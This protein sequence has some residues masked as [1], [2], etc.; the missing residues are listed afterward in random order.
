MPAIEV[1]PVSASAGEPVKKVYLIN[2]SLSLNAGIAAIAQDYKV[3]QKPPTGLLYLSASLKRGGVDSVV[4]DQNVDRISFEKITEMIKREAPLFTGIY[5]DFY[6]QPYVLRLVDLIK[7]QL[8]AMTVVV[9]GPACCDYE[10]LHEHKVDIVC[11]GEG[12]LVVGDIAAYCSKD[13]A[14]AH[15]RG[16]SYLEDGRIVK[17]RARPRIDDLDS[18]PFPSF[19]KVDMNAYYDYHIFGMER[20]FFTLIASRGCPNRCTYCSSH[21]FWQNRC[22]LR[23][24]KN[25]VD[26]IELLVTRYGIRYIA[27]N[28][29]LFGYRKE[30]LYEFV[31]EIK[32]REI[33]MKFYCLLGP[34]SLRGERRRLLSLLRSIG[35]DIIVTGL[36]S[37]D[38]DVLRNIN[39][40]PSDPEALAEL[41]REAK[42]LGITTAVHFIYG[43][44]GDSIAVFQKNLDYALSVRPHYALF[45]MLERMPGSKIYEE[46]GTKP[47][48]ELSDET[49]KKWVN[50]SQAA[51]FKDP[52]VIAQN[53][54]HILQK[55]PS[56]LWVG[57][58]NVLHLSRS[59]LNPY[60]D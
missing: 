47:A 30:W 37:V 48:T 58:R 8:P 9:G 28:D 53:L 4:I 7:R 55:K 1:D 17:N 29:D 12:D 6:L 3:V 16:I 54:L 10:L 27:F 34:S 46:Y 38:P 5:A 32:A 21:D 39:R 50:S 56:W 31:D 57:L 13:M 26:E 60:F 20:P 19:D 35:L 24:V 14:L 51:F 36:Q 40:H 33:E 43:L 52:R 42:R 25:V 44:P 49:I 15:I 41:I 23:S 18:L 11:H 22:R 2:P 45:Y 59:A